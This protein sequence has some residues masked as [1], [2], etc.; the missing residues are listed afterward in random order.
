M[1]HVSARST[2]RIQRP[3]V[4]N[5]F[6]STISAAQGFLAEARANHTASEAIEEP[7]RFTIFELDHLEKSVANASEWFEGKKLAQE[8][9]KEYED[10]V[11]TVAEVEKKARDVSTELVRL[12]KKKLPRKSK[13]AK[14]VAQVVEEEPTVEPEVETPV[15]EDGEKQEEPVVDVEEAVVGEG[16]VEPVIIERAKDEL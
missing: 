4:A 14:K 16:T 11:Y 8:D 6:H 10:P 1:K 3:I 2:E 15:V 13:L 7:T 9:V 5:T 12:M